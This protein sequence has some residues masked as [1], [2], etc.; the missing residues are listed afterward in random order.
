VSCARGAHL[1]SGNAEETPCG[2]GERLG[3]IAFV[4]AEP[5]APISP[6]TAPSRDS[7]IKPALKPSDS[8]HEASRIQPRRIR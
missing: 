5:A 7:G 8:L 2:I 6:A 3:E 1:E 4:V